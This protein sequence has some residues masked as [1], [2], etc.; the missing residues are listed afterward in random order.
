MSDEM[1]WQYD[2]EEYIKQGEPGKIE[3]SEEWQTAIGL[4]AV[5]DF[6][7]EKQFSHEG[8]SA[9]ASIRHLARFAS[10]I[11]QIHSFCEGN[12]RATAVQ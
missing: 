1:K 12:T 3:K 2:L 5:N 10:E 8:L 4:Q 11:W 7:T 9:E 6:A